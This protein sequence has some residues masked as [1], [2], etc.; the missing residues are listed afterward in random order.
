ML[1]NNTHFSIEVYYSEMDSDDEVQEI[2]PPVITRSGRKKYR[3]M[4]LKEELD[5]VFLS[6]Q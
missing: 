3:R 4:I 1:S 5:P 2:D 6:P